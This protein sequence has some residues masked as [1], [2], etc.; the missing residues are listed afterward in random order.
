MAGEVRQTA[1]DVARCVAAR[2]L[3][4]INLCT[5]GSHDRRGRGNAAW[6]QPFG[7]NSGTQLF[8]TRQPCWHRI[9]ALLWSQPRGSVIG[10]AR[11]TTNTRTRC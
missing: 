11:L 4:N 1:V 5:Y 7:P 2:T 9:R 8:I 3:R 6:L 10:K